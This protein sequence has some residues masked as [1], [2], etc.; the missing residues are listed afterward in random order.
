MILKCDLLFQ[1][2]RD[3]QIQPH[4][5]YILPASRKNPEGEA[6]E[7]CAD[8]LLKSQQH[9]GTLQVKSSKKLKHC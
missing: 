6:G 1:S 4:H 3:Q 9:Q 8:P 2:P 7:G 5:S